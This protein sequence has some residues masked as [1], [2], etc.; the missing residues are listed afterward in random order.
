MALFKVEQTTFYAEPGTKDRDLIAKRT[1]IYEFVNKK[2]AWNMFKRSIKEFHV[3]DFWEG[4]TWDKKVVKSTHYDENGATEMVLTKWDGFDKDV[5][6]SWRDMD[7]KDY[8]SKLGV[9]R[10]HPNFKDCEERT[11]HDA[12]FLEAEDGETVLFHA[13]TIWDNEEESEVMKW[14]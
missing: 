5:K 2:D 6:L 10:K 11:N 4:I 1:E 7:G 14:I 9:I 12:A 8:R 3:M 13:E